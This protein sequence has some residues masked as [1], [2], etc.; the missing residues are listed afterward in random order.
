MINA[1]E[2]LVDSG[3]NKES[4]VHND[5]GFKILKHSEI[6][7]DIRAQLLKMVRATFCPDAESVISYD[8]HSLSTEM[9]IDVEYLVVAC[10]SHAAVD[11]TET[12][13]VP[14]KWFDPGFDYLTAYEDNMIHY[15]KEKIDNNECIKMNIQEK[16]DG[17]NDEIEDLDYENKSFND[18][19]NSILDKQKSRNNSLH[20]REN[21]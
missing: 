15:F 18:N 20:C 12:C 19:I 14:L 9:V 6:D 4:N 11:F 2:E 17:L 1:K 7:L 10:D 3:D 13:V 21:E 8:M 16:I 5:L